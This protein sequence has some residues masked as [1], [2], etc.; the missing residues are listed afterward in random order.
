M[1]VA[2][3]LATAGAAYWTLKPADEDL[4]PQPRPA[5]AARPA[6]AVPSLAE[7]PAASAPAGSGVDMA[8]VDG[9]LV[10]PS[11]EGLSPARRVP[12]IRIMVDNDRE[13]A[14]PPLR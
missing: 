3:V 4:P 2:A 9:D 12:T 10:P 7:I 14:P 11:T 5:A 1:A 6:I 8:N 13:I